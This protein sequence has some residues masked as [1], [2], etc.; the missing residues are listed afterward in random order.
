[1]SIWVDRDIYEGGWVG[2]DFR[3]LFLPFKW[4]NKNKCVAPRSVL[5]DDFSSLSH[6]GSCL[7][8]TALWQQ[9]S[10]SFSVSTN[11]L[12][13]VI[14]ELSLSFSFSISWS[15]GNP[16]EAIGLHGRTDISALYIN[17]MELCTICL[18][19]LLMPFE[20]NWVWFQKYNFFETVD[21]HCSLNFI[22][23]WIW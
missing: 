21:C 3:P 14:C 13:W 4:M 7:K 15:W 12:C 5:W 23:W 2:G 10:S 1:M 19:D 6:L 20:P 9:F 8:G 18:C 11:I 16:H 22:T 17:D